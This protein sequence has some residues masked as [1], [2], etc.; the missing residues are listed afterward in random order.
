MRGCVLSYSSN[1]ERRDAVFDRP[2]SSPSASV[3][4]GPPLCQTH[5]SDGRT[6]TQ[7]R[8][9]QRRSAFALAV[10]NVL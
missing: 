6:R 8:W 1:P 9:Q 5:T 7:Q 4:V 3:C 10:L 2:P